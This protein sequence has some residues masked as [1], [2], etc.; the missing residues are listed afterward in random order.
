MV[1]S[2][3]LMAITHAIAPVLV[4][5]AQETFQ[6]MPECLKRQQAERAP[7]TVFQQRWFNSVVDVPVDSKILTDY[8]R[9]EQFK[10]L[11]SLRK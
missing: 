8:E 5:T 9:Q 6:S 4:N 11:V 10:Q 7:L 3:I 1:Y 2:R